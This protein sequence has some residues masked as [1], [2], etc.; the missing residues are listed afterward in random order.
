[1]DRVTKSYF[2]NL[3]AKDKDPEKRRLHDFLAVCMEM[4]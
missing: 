3:E 2:E 4:M 1:M